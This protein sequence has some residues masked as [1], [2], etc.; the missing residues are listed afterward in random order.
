MKIWPKWARVAFSR[1]RRSLLG[2]ESVCSWRKTTLV[3]I[4][5]Q[6]S[7]GDKAPPLP[8]FARPP[9]DLK[10]LRVS[11]DRRFVVGLQDARFAPFAEV[12]CR[13]GVDV[14]DAW[15][16]KQFR[17]A[18]DDANQ[19]VGAASVVDLLH[20]GRDLVIRLGDHVFD[21][22]SGGIVARGAERINAC[23]QFLRLY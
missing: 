14:V 9:G 21:A 1:F 22:Y 5:F 4:L 6:P 12:A 23:H 7:E 15:L 13:S 10:T 19:I 20:C 2:L 3:G 18:K 16:V 11:K 17:Q 8:H